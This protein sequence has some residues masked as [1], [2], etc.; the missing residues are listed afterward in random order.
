[1][2]EIQTYSTKFFDEAKKYVQLHFKSNYGNVNEK[3]FFPLT[4]QQANEHLENFIF[5][6]LIY[7]GPYQDAI[8]FSHP[9]LFHST[10]SAALNV[11][12]I[13]PKTIIEKVISAYDELKSPIQSIEGFIRQIVGWREYVRL[14]YKYF[15]RKIRT[16][17]FFEFQKGLSL[18]KFYSNNIGIFP[19]DKTLEK[20]HQTAYNHHIERLMLLGNL[21]LLLEIHPDDVYEFFMTNY[22]D[23]YDW[24]MVPNVYGM[25]QYADGGLMATKPYISSSKYILKM[26]NLKK[27]DWCEKW[28]NL[29]WNFL[30]KHHT[31][32]QYNPRMIYLIKHTE[33]M[34]IE[35]IKKIQ[36]AANSIKNE[37]L[38]S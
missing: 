18:E 25:S 19:V 23:A 1:L 29:F 31:K 21:F 12:L 2:P 26:S 33:K 32:L 28:D 13:T 8:E 14:I 7:F 10:I 4:F 6:K 30:I 5:D 22:I 24:V 3:S 17:N 27:D 36:K 35:K 11:G 20:L 38:L 9:F 15:G 34:S 16:S 37:L